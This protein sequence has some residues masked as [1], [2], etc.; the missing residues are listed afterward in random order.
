MRMLCEK[1]ITSCGYAAN[2]LLPDMTKAFDTIN[3]EHLYKPL[4]GQTF[5]TTLGSPQGDCLSAIPFTLFLSYTLSAIIP[6]HLHGHI[7]YGAHYVFLSPIEHIHYHNYCLK[8]DKDHITD[9]IIDQH[10]ADDIRFI[11]NSKTIINKVMINI[12]PTIQKKA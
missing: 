3:R 2:I 7:Y 8:Q 1:A 12:A 9:Y 10:Y 5:T 11:S 6:A 4:S